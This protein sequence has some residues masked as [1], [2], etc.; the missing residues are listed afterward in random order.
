MPASAASAAEL[1][2]LAYRWLARRDRS[3][4]EMR[5][6][7]ERHCSDA[8]TVLCL[9]DELGARGWLCEDRLA[10]QVIR[11]RR[12][13]SSARGI[14]HAMARRGIADE[15]I[16]Q[17][18]AGLEA[19]DLHSA[20]QLLRKRFRLPATDRTER[21]RQFRFLLNRGFDRSVALKAVRAAGDDGAIDSAD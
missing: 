1:S 11:L 2:A 16:A 7:L 13:R 21:E 14:R 15:V 3:R 5:A 12:T 9:L 10:D 6:Y 4:A 19:G 8:D 20:T 17:S 18:T